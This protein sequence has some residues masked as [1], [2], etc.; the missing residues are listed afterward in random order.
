MPE[1]TVLMTVYNGMPYL[2]LAIESI[3]KQT[4]TDFE[5]LIINDCSTDNSRD[6]IQ[7]YGDPRIRLLD[8]EENINQTRSLNRG[9]EHTRTEL[10]A[11]M[12]ADDISHPKRLERQVAYLREHPEV[13]AVGTNLRFIDHKGKVT[14]QFI[15]PEH[16]LALRWMQLFSCPISCGAMMFRKSVVWDK[17]GGFDPSISIA[18][19][20]ELWSRVLPQYK[21]VNLPDL[22]LD[23]R[24]HPGCDTIALSSIAHEERKRINRANPRRILGITD[25]S[26][27]WLNKVD[28]LIAKRVDHPEHLLEVIE[29][30]FERF[31]ALY[32]TAE[33]DPEIL[34]ELSRQYLRVLCH[35]DLRSLPTAF[36]V[37]RLAWPVSPKGL[38]IYWLARSLAIHAGGRQVKRWIRSVLDQVNR[39][40]I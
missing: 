26:E 23:V 34:K 9:L 1:V 39:E 6:V 11:R 36:R 4:W 15:R 31:C 12:D 10:V 35:T 32:P 27:K 29:V 28:T 7:S 25:N 16:N 40:R 5:F 38:Y 37:L 8:N 20:W 21:I 2:P 13:V 14:G 24:K 30:L 19:D 18:Q 3:L 17:L 22:L 33:A